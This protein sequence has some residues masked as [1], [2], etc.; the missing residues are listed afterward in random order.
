MKKNGNICHALIATYAYFMT[1]IFV[2]EILE[3]M[4]KGSTNPSF[5]S[6][7]G[8]DLENLK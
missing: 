6:K 5:Q 8:T 1:V 7:P 2:T 3:C 4:N